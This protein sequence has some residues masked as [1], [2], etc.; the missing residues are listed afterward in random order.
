MLKIIVCV[1]FGFLNVKFLGALGLW[2]TICIV[3]GDLP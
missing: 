2:T 1:V 3:S